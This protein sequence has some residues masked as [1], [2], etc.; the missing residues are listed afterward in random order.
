MRTEEIYVIK[1][2]A[3]RDNLSLSDQQSE[4]IY[5]YMVENGMKLTLKTILEVII[6][7]WLAS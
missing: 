1:R 7:L 6:I 4:E 5:A 3:E 2:L